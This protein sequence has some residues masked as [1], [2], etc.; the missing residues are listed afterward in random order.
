MDLQDL[1]ALRGA[2]ERRYDEAKDRR[3]GG[4]IEAELAGQGSKRSSDRSRDGEGEEEKKILAD[5]ERRYDEAKDRRGGGI[6]A[7]V[8]GE[9]SK[10]RGR[11]RSGG[12]QEAIEEAGR[13]NEWD[14]KWC[15]DFGVGFGFLKIRPE[16]DLL[17]SLA[18]EVEFRRL[19]NA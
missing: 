16:S 5:R 2:R 3:G 19:L 7:E 18:K 11:D 15:G 13:R 12:N 10:R 6:E 1:R 4:G 17:A 9:G 14:L 8:M